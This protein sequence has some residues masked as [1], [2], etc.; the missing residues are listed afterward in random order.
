MAAVRKGDTETAKRLSTPGYLFA[1]KASSP[2]DPF[3]T[4][5]VWE[6]A[7]RDA[8]HVVW[9]R[10]DATHTNVTYIT[11]NKTTGWRYFLM[12]TKE[13]WKVDAGLHGAYEPN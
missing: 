13:G 9:Q 3:Y 1:C 5:R 4:D 12:K 2:K 6:K 8:P 7:A 10:P 11:A